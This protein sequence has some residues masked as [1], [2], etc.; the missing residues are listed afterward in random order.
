[1][2]RWRPSALALPDAVELDIGTVA[3]IIR[4]TGAIFVFGTLTHAVERILEIE[5]GRSLRGSANH[6]CSLELRGALVGEHLVVYAGDTKQ[7]GLPVS[8]LKEQTVCSTG[9]LLPYHEK[10]LQYLGGRLTQPDQIQPKGRHGWA[11]STHLASEH[12]A[13]RHHLRQ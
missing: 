8:S 7:R 3:A 2:R 1:M 12:L 9:Y 13:A 10:V 4:V 5:Q 6:G 11:Q